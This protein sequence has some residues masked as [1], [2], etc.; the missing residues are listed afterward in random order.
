MSDLSNALQSPAH[1]SP[2]ARAGRRVFPRRMLVGLAAVCGGISIVRPR[3]HFGKYE[4]LGM[5]AAAA[6]FTSF[7]MGGLADHRGRTRRAGHHLTK[8][9]GR[10][11]LDRFLIFI[12]ASLEQTFL[13]NFGRTA[14]KWER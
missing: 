4:A 9:F 2:L 6:R 14:P 3:D 7:F 1:A 12:R 13:D 10:Q 8:C 11:P 5:S